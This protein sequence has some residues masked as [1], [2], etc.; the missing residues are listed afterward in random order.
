M[1]HSNVR[2]FQ[3]GSVSESPVDWQQQQP[4]PL[5]G[6]RGKGDEGNRSHILAVYQNTRYVLSG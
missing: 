5:W 6:S 3:E 1:T 2:V 4:Q